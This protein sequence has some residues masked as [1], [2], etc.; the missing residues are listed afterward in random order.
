M[1]LNAEKCEF[2]VTGHR[3]KHLWLNVGESQVWEK[4]QVKLLGLKFDNHITKICRK[5]NSKLGAFSRLARYLLMKQKK[6]LYMPFT[7]AQFKYCPIT[8]KKTAKLINSKK[9]R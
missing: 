1:K 9:G 6:L 3:F 5:A 8:W 2:L 4:N 7:E